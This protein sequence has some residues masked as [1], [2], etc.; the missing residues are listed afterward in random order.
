MTSQK[1][2]GGD[3]AKGKGSDKTPASKEKSGYSERGM[4]SNNKEA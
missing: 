4:K 3:G 1:E 2:E